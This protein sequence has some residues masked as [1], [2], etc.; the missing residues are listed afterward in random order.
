MPG[1]TTDKTSVYSFRKLQPKREQKGMIRTRQVFS[2]GF[3]Q[4]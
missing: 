4:I 1:F 3:I 2:A